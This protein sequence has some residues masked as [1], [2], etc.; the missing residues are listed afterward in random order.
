M[1]DIST[2]T[3]FTTFSTNLAAACGIAHRVEAIADAVATISDIP[4]HGDDRV[5]WV[6]SRLRD[7]QPDLMTALNDAGFDLKVPDDPATVRDQPVGLTI[8]RI[9]IA[10]T[11]SLLLHEPEVA[12]RSVSLMTNVLIVIC[13]LDALVPSLDEAGEAL[14]EISTNGSSYATFVTGPSRTADIERQ[15]T[16]GVQGPAAM[17]V[18]FIAG[19]ASS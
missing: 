19:N 7:A 14:R 2:D 6:S 5:I 9:G 8:A 16:I 15:L 11:G 17:H 1:S 13:P 3:L 18:V 4:G 10:E 12:D